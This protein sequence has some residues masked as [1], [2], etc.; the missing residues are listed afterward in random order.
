MLVKKPSKKLIKL[1]KR[2]KIKLTRKS[3][4][5]KRVYKSSKQLIKEIKKKKPNKFIKNAN[6]NSVKKG[7][8]GSFRK[9]CKS[10]GLSSKSGKVTMKCIKHGLKDKSVLIRRRANYARNIGGYTNS[11]GAKKRVPRLSFGAKRSAFGLDQQRYE[12]YAAVDWNVPKSD[13]TKKMWKRVRRNCEGGR[14]S[15]LDNEI[16]P[17]MYVNLGH[18]KCL[19]VQEILKM[20]HTNRFVKDSDGNILNPFT[21]QPLTR[22]QLI[23]L[24]AIIDAEKRLLGANVPVPNDFSRLPDYDDE[25]MNT[26]TYRRALKN[27]MMSGT[28][29]EDELKEAFRR[30]AQME[31]YDTLPNTMFTTTP[32]DIFWR[33]NNNKLQFKRDLIF[34]PESEWIDMDE[35]LES[36]LVSNIDEAIHR[37]YNSFGA[38]RRPF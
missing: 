15:I 13:F 37:H 30:F 19:S 3:K 25:D 21:R 31:D 36:E 10:K 7:T 8:V 24:N 26:Q 6:K 33:I 35:V 5:G 23:K 16:I 14:S 22:K 20:H 18:K 34:E 1:C 27:I 32:R 2:L 17:G 28:L 12:N 9:W 29:N 4:S 11:F 38:K